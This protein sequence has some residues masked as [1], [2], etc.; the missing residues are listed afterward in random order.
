MPSGPPSSASARLE[1]ARPRAAARGSAALGRY[2]GLATTRSSA[3][4]R[5]A[6][7][8]RRSPATSRDASP[9]PSARTLPAATASAAGEHVGRDHASRG[10]AAASAQAMAPLPV[11][12]SA[13]QPASGPRPRGPRAPIRTS[14]S[15][16]GRGISTSGVTARRRPWKSSQPSRCCSGSRRRAARDE[17]AVAR[18][19]RR[20][21]PAAAVGLQV[22]REALRRRGRAASSHSASCRAVAAARPPRRRASRLGEQRRG[23]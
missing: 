16:S 23:T 14:P 8:A 4:A 15:V 10:S 3:P 19:P 13:T 11:P 2:G 20:P 6:S 22:E 17:R 9:S 7:G 5:A 21:R 1:G 18:A 12:M